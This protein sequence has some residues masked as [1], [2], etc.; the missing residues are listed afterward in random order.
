LETGIID[1]FATAGKKTKIAAICF[2]L[3]KL[4]FF[5]TIVSA[6]VNINIAIVNLVMYVGLIITSATLCI[7]E[8]ME[9]RE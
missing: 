9:L 1:E 7:M 2:V 8:L 5:L 4:F 6:F 3:A